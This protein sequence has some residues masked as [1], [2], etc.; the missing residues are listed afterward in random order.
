MKFAAMLALSALILAGCGDKQRVASSSKT[1][2]STT[3]TDGR[4]HPVDMQL[5]SGARVTCLSAVGNNGTQGKCNVNGATVAPPSES[6]TAT[7][8]VYL[9]CEGTPPVKCTAEVVE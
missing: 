9:L 6:V 7:G 4:M 3:D 5:S 8:K 1:I 2:T